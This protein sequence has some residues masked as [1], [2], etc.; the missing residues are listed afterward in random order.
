MATE[1]KSPLG[2]FQDLYRDQEHHNIFSIQL[3]EKKS[4]SFELN[5]NN[6]R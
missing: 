4:M 1:K 6:L 5:E 3:N 2:Y